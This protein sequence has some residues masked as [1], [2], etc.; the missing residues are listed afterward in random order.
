[1]GL[2][3]LKK[4]AMETMNDQALIDLIA[5][6]RKEKDDERSKM[7][8]CEAMIKIA[9]ETESQCFDVLNRRREVEIESRATAIHT[10]NG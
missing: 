9:Q 6:C 4:E 5:R 2:I 3:G 10:G 7:M 8:D 1:M